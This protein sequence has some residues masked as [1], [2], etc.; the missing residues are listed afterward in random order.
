MSATTIKNLRKLTFAGDLTVFMAW[1]TEAGFPAIAR[2]NEEL[3]VYN[4]YVGVPK[5]HPLY[6][7]GYNE[8]CDCLIAPSEKEPLGKRSILPFLFRSGDGTRQVVE[9]VFD[10]HGGLTYGRASC[11]WE[12]KIY[13]DNGYFP[14]HWWFGFDCAH[15]GDGRH[16]SYFER[17][18]KLLPDCP[19]LWHEIPGDRFRDLG[20]VTKECESLAA[21]M[22]T[23]VRKRSLWERLGHFFH[24]IMGD[25]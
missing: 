8:H 16:P 23:R 9:C 1:V 21:Q 10:V 2:F 25:L 4:G 3:G 18:R 19:S 15:A 20:Y 5:S 24:R 22:I 7:V 6:E 12:G 13:P 11:E 17:M 14:D